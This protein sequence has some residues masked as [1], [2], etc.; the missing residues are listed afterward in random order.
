MSKSTL[1]VYGSM[2]KGMV[3]HN[4][5]AAMVKEIK[6]ASCEGVLY[7]LPVGYPVMMEG[8]GAVK[9]ELL[10]L[11]SFKDIIK[12]IDEFEGYS[13]TTP[14][15]SSNLR[16][17]KPVLVD[18]AKKPSMSFVYLLNP[19]KLPK[20]ATRIES[21]DY[22]EVMA[23]QPPLSNQLSDSQKRYIL[24]LGASSGRDIVPINLD[25][26]R[27]LLNKGLI[28]DKGRRLALTNLGFDVYKY[29]A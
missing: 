13:A 14:D 12:I 28:V 8:A 2:M 17:E 11:N 20:D 5:L 1:F 15:K 22:K 25:I 23:A 27:D 29:L 6:P 3:H 21:G 9:G 4:K 10:T 24:K 18:G 7:R 26:Y 19:L 16:V